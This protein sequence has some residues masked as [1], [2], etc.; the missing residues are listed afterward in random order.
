MSGRGDIRMYVEHLFEGRT[1]DAET[2]ELKEE[3][4]GNLTARFDDYVA[5]GMSEQEAFSRTCEAVTSVDDVLGG[6]GAEAEGTGAEA[7][8]ATDAE[9]TRTVPVGVPPVSPE[10]DEAR[11]P[12]GRRRWSTGRIVGV[13]AVALVAVVALCTVINIINS[14]VASATYD[15]PGTVDVQP[16]DATDGSTAYP[17]AGSGADAGTQGDEHT[18]RTDDVAQEI[19]G[20]DVASLSAMADSSWPLDGAAVSELVGGMPL[21][22]HLMSTGSDSTERDGNSIVVEYEWVEDDRVARTDDDVVEQALAHNA[23]ALLCAA[24]SADSV[25]MVTHET[26]GEDGELSVDTFTFRRDDV[27]SVLGTDLTEG[28]LSDG[29]W[30]ELRSKLSTERYYDRLCDLADRD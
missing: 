12:E 25:R 9:A 16:L 2:I 18:L 23:T 4:Y 21:A 3:I 27:E 28:R 17:S 20:Y 19:S 10:T 30:D 15:T 26:D 24:G 7:E 6:R 29:T 14:S 22:S 1:L 13:A 8:G 11:G 5:Q